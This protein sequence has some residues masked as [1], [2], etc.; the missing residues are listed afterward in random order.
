MIY[1]FAGRKGDKLTITMNRVTGNLDARVVI[2]DV[3]QHVLASDDDSGGHQNALLTFAVPSTG[4]YYL[5]ATR[6]SGT[7]GDPNT[8]GTYTLAITQAGG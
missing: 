3:N 7:D 4:V 2:L 1:A 5:A 8:T 6:F